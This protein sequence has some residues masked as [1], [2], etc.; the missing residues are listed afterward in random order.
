MTHVIL[1]LLGF[2]D[3]L[4]LALQLRLL[5]FDFLACDGQLL[6]GLSKI[7]VLLFSLSQGRIDTILLP[8]GFS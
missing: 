8:L 2:S 5:N 6:L 3:G 1:G 7:E 4:G